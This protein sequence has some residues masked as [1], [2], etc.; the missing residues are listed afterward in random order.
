M[1]IY[2]KRFFDVIFSVILIILLL[3]IFIP[4]AFI[5]IF[6]D[7]HQV[8][9]MQNR[10]GYNNKE[11]KIFKF[12]TM[13]KNSMK[14]GSGSITLRNDPRVTK[15]GSFLRITK[16]NELPQV[17][18]VLIGDMSFVGP[19]PLLRS[20]FD[21]YENNAR[22]II[23]KNK[24][25]ITGVGSIVFRDEEKLISESSEDPHIYYKKNISPI[26]ANLEISYSKHKS[27]YL[28]LKILIFTAI[29][30]LYPSFETKKLFKF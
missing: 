30:I 15:F 25:G 16:I 7:E 8:F 29:I 23:S 19:R 1:Y 9:Y 14:M 22:Q 11:F 24:P 18:N 20:T 5:L 13:L 4:V 2:L 3:P 10:V 27:F 26:K 12:A 28:D 6:S 21:L 17:F